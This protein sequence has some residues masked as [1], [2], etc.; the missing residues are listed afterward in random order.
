MHENNSKTFVTATTSVAAKAKTANLRQE[1]IIDCR[2]TPEQLFFTCGEV[3]RSGRGK[4]CSSWDGWGC[5]EDYFHIPDIHFFGVNSEKTFSLKRG[6]SR[7][8]FC[9]KK[10]GSREKNLS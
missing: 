8:N 2:K 4:C 3:D 1:N 6:A 5:W 7:E 10:G 9:L